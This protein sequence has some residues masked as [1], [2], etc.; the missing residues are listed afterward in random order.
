[1]DYRAERG[2]RYWLPSHVLARPRIEGT[3]L[4]DLKHNRY[5]ALSVSD[6]MTLSR[7]VPN[8]PALPEHASCPAAFQSQQAAKAYA[9]TLLKSG[10]LSA[11]EPTA[12]APMGEVVAPRAAVGEEIFVKAEITVD[13]LAVFVRSYC[14]ARRS[15]RDRPLHDIRQEIV[16]MR[17][18]GEASATAAIDSGTVRLVSAFRTLRPCS[19]TA[20][21]RC[22]V[23]SLA[24][25][26]FLAHYQVFPTWV[27]GVALRPW[28]AHSWIQLREL[29]LDST[30]EK[31]CPF[32]P[33]L[34]V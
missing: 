12:S 6:S 9:A 28:G 20:K 16:A 29:V 18:A 23:H 1:M 24:L 19:F 26:K 32:T 5:F 15:V 11:A 2:Q 34:V 22:L 14:W 13:L 8:W 10:L 3:V 25:L 30:P 7:I 27:I 17:A 31:V 33:I 4:L 21:D